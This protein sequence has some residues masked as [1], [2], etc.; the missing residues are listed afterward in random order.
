MSNLS[1]NNPETIRRIVFTVRHYYRYKWMRHHSLETALVVL[2]CYALQL[3]HANLIA[4]GKE[5]EQQIAT[6]NNNTDIV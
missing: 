3:E 1:I 2:E 6:F 5:L 4:K